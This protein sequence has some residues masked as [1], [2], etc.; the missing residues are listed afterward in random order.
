MNRLKKW[1]LPEDDGKFWSMRYWSPADWVSFGG[2]VLALVLLVLVVAFWPLNDAVMRYLAGV[3]ALV[4]LTDFADGE[5]AKRWGGSLRGAKMDELGD[6]VKAIPTLVALAVL[7]PGKAN[8][9]LVATLILRDV[10]ATVIR[11]RA[12]REGISTI[13]SARWPGKVKT[14][15]IFTGIV[16]AWVPLGNNVV[17]NAVFSVAT[18]VSIV[19][20]LEIWARYMAAKDIERFIG[21]HYAVS[22]LVTRDKKTGKMALRTLGA[23]NWLSFFRF[24]VGPVVCAIY[25]FQ[26]LGDDSNTVALYLWAVGMATDGIDGF[27]A[28]RRRETTLFGEKFDPA[29]DKSAQYLPFV[30]IAVCLIKIGIPAELMRLSVAVSLGVFLARDLYLLVVWRKTKTDPKPHFVSK[31]RAVAMAVAV[32]LIA[33]YLAY[34]PRVVLHGAAIAIWVAAGISVLSA[35]V[36]R[37]SMISSKNTGFAE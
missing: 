31:A 33:I 37:Q 26:L 19:S 27:M 29:A 30:G 25:C 9:M 1:P 34:G 10:V 22:P 13:K 35:I 20:G 23:A 18:L 36:E 2:T 15:L 4:A 24:A 7:L 14:T 12:A 28:R 32:L 5:V 21:P 3:W 17:V 11:T 6:K 8:W 16:L